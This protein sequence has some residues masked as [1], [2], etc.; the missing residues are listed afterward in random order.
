MTADNKKPVCVDCDKRTQK[1]L[2][3]NDTTSSQ[4]GP[5]DIMYANVTTCMKRENGQIA[6]CVKEW[7]AFKKCHADN[8]R[9][10]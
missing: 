5:C 9:G 10:H 7:D 4:G 1:D 6:P 8:P 2:P 3:T